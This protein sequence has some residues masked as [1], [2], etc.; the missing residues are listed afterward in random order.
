MDK[1]P[2]IVRVLRQEEK[3]GILN[4]QNHSK[5]EQIL[6]TKKTHY[7]IKDSTILITDDKQ[8]E[9]TSIGAETVKW[10]DTSGTL[11]DTVI[12]TLSDV[13]YVI[14]Q[15]G[16]FLKWNTSL[17]EITGYSYKE[18]QSL[19]PTDFFTKSDLKKVS[20]EIET[21][22]EKKSVNFEADFKP[23]NGRII[24]MIFSA[25]LMLD[26]CGNSFIF[27]IGKDISELKKLQQSVAE[28]TKAIED[29][30]KQLDDLI[31]NAN[32]MIQSVDARLK[33]VYVNKAWRNKLGYSESEIKQLK[34]TDILKKDQ[35]QHCLK[36]FEKVSKDKRKESVETVFI[37]KV[38][39][40]I[41]VEGKVNGLFKNGEFLSTRAIFRDITKRKKADE[42]LNKAHKILHNVN[43]EL[44]KMVEKR[45]TQIQNLL[46]QKDQFIG[47]LGHDLKTPLSIL[48]NILPMINESIDNPETKEDCNIA[49]RNV[50]YIKH[51]V[52]ETLH[53]AELS[54]PTLVLEKK[55]VNLKT[56]IS[57]VIE[58]NDPI[59]N[60]KNIRVMNLILSDIIVPIDELKIKEVLYN[61]LSNALKFTH[62]GGTI[63]FDSH[64]TG[65]NTVTIEVRDTGIGMNPDQ[66]KNVF[67]DFYK[68]DMSRHNLGGSGLGLGIC[69][70]IIE[71]HDGRMWADSDGGEK[72][73]RFY[74]KLFK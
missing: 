13:F 16:Q 39:K 51:L 25:K 59:S 44:E 37:S 15:H 35:I 7:S 36:A 28:N 42:Q 12:N 21:I 68:A 52:V 23:K 27:C 56:L 49:L 67:N 1:L 69:K 11:L 73:S 66:M 50:N 24:P 40:E 57:E 62:E 61:L 74:F 8:T 26:E 2:D 32:D 3:Q 14:D 30:E 4:F 65:D 6:E 72:G 38:G 63:T 20:K 55:D 58:D 31:E 46:I 54:S 48:V 17:E 5:M 60:A 45:T 19:K 43:Q 33:F 64:D 29:S 71:K 53:I 41:T 70:R 47:Q 22:F 18:I 34:L 9:T 10:Q